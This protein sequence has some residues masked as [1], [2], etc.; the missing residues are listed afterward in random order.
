[1]GEINF[2]AAQGTTG[3]IVVARLN[4]GTDI[5]DGIEKMCDDYNIESAIITTVIGS[6]ARAEFAFVVPRPDT[7]MKAGKGDPLCLEGPLDF[8]SAQGTIGKDQE[9]KRYTHM[10]GV[11]ADKL[12]RLYGGH[13]TKGKNPVLL[14]VEVSLLELTGMQLVRRYYEETNSYQLSPE[15]SE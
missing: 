10:H 6:I 15:R 12:D 7:K 3:R 11:L 13:M 1:M 4:S 8:L 9:G 14:T 2:R 5:I